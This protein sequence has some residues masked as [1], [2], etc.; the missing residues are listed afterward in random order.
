MELD[1]SGLLPYEGSNFQELNG[2]NT[3][4]PRYADLMVYVGDGQDIRALNSRFLI[5]HSWN[6][7]ICILRRPLA[8]TLDVVASR[9]YLK[10]KNH[11]LQGKLPTVKRC[12]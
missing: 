8:A 5:V 7:Y 11:N 2:N 3:P 10:L 6:V 12:T 9:V 4:P 1:Q